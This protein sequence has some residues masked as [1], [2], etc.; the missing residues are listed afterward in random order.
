MR[1]GQGEERAGKEEQGPRYGWEMAA[2][3]SQWTPLGETHHVLWPWK[4]NRAGAGVYFDFKFE[5]VVVVVSSVPF[6]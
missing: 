1:A 2:L 5:L 6:N 3:C 4:V